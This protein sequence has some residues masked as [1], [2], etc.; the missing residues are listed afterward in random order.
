MIDVCILKKTMIQE[1][2]NTVKMMSKRIWTQLKQGS[3]TKEKHET[4]ANGPNDLI[5]QLEIYLVVACRESYVLCCQATCH[6]MRLPG[7]AWESGAD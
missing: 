4:Y 3:T 6:P 1:L 2:S 7:H 5:L